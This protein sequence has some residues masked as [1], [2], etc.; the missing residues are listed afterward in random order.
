MEEQRKKEMEVER[1]KAIKVKRLR[2]V[3]GLE[4]RELI[5]AVGELA[6][7]QWG[8]RLAMEV[9]MRRKE[10]RERKSEKEKEKGKEK[11]KES[12]VE[13]D[14]SDEEKD[15]DREKD[16]EN[17]EEDEKEDEDKMDVSD[18]FLMCYY[19]NIIIT[20][21]YMQVSSSVFLLFL[22]YNIFSSFC[23][24]ITNYIIGNLCSHSLI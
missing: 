9:R 2:R 23:C 16:G 22:F 13:M 14:K 6:E 3:E 21:E 5:E 1:E 18:E 15:G 20:V 7:E 11:E 8:I 4:N 17:E 12:D 24:T 19:H 10:E